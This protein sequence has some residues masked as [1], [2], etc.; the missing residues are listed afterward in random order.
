MLWG[1]DV[2]KICGEFIGILLELVGVELV[3]E[4]IGCIVCYELKSLIEVGYFWIDI[5]GNLLGIFWDSF[6]NI[7]ELL[8]DLF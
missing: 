4:G 3:K 5:L 6:V 1:L 8:D 7:I 2:I